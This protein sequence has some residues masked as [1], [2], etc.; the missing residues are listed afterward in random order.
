MEEAALRAAEHKERGNAYFKKGENER[1]NEEYVV[2]LSILEE[3]K[4]EEREL[5]TSL[6]LNRA[7]AL[8][9]LCRYDE[10]HKCANAACKLQ[11]DN[12]KALYRRGVACVKLSRIDAAVSDFSRALELEPTNRDARRELLLVNKKK[13]QPPRIKLG[14]LY[15]DVEAQRERRKL[16]EEAAMA[17]KR[18]RHEEANEE[19]EKK[20]MK[21]LSFDE[22]VKQDDEAKKKTEDQQK[23]K[24]EQEEKRRDELRRKQRRE[25]VVVIDDDDDLTDCKGYKVLADGRKTS[26]FTNVP[27][28]TTKELLENQSG[29]QK[30]DT[31]LTREASSGSAWNAAG[32]TVE[33]RPQ[34]K[35]ADDAL[36]RHLEPV[37]VV[38]GSV[39]VTVTQVKKLTGE[40]SI[41]VSRRTPKFI[42]DYTATLDWE[43]SDASSKTYKGSVHLPDLSSTVTDGK[44]EHSFSFKTSNCPKL[45]HAALDKLKDAI[46]AALANFVREYHQRQLR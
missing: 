37:A 45:V 34:T 23:K 40:A 8:I 21:R 24:K 36:K 17:V 43:A 15:G 33:E 3:S 14:G 29:P 35:W 39:S 41:I 30:L 20:G 12:V 9:K 44:Y 2:G 46:D 16:E 19:R 13:Q 27:D 11:P 6:E 38:H 26:Y 42:F 25:E 4:S 28:D 18:R 31:V 1:A 5:Q 7:M 32:T 22:W 10:A